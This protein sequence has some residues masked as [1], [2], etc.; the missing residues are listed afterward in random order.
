MNIDYKCHR[1]AYSPFLNV[2]L[3]H[4]IRSAPYQ[5][6]LGLRNNSKYQRPSSA[7]TNLAISAFLLLDSS[8]R[9]VLSFDQNVSGIMLY[10]QVLSRHNKCTGH[11][12]C[13]GVVDQGRLACIFDA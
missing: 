9:P 8:L 6:L 2:F 5:R 12:L 3:S 4:G 1:C 10:R 13:A 11:V 7:A